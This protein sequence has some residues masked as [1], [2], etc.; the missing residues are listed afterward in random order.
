MVRMNL[1]L[2]APEWRPR[3]YIRA[4]LLEEGYDVLAVELGG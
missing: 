1:L 2:V 4:Q 3:A